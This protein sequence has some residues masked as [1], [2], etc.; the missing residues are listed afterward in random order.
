MSDPGESTNR[1]RACPFFGNVARV[2]L[3]EGSRFG[4]EGGD[5]CR[6]GTGESFTPCVLQS[7]AVFSAARLALNIICR[8]MGAG[9]VNGCQGWS[10]VRSEQMS[11]SVTERRARSTRNSAERLVTSAI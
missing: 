8:A 1:L 3:W 6:S 4:A 5:F 10:E 7:I 2:A 11:G 9:G